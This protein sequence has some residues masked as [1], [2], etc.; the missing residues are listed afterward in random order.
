[1]FASFTPALAVA[2]TV[3]RLPVTIVAGVMGLIVGSFLN[4]V[5]YR[6]PRHLSVVRPPSFCPRCH[7][8]VGAIENVPVVSWL[9]LR[10]R[11]RHC[12]EPISPRYPL[13]EALTGAV[14]ALLGWVIGPHWAVLGCCVLAATVL[15]LA[16][17]ALDAMDPPLSVALMG[18]GIGTALLVVAG[19]ADHRWPRLVASLIGIGAGVVVMAVVAWV[20]RA[21]HREGE[22]S[23]VA[24]ALPV[25]ALVGWVGPLSGA[26]AA[27][28]A[29]IV[30]GAIS[31][32]RPEGRTHAHV[33]T[34]AVLALAIGGAIGVAVAAALGRVTGT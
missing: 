30:L 19:A 20:L 21:T 16:S 24:A 11:C 15:T 8:P 10:G 7:A 34:N 13:V 25:G 18:T 28:S 23:S 26:V 31:Q 29:V 9:A 3:G 22:V 12:G 1:M 27:A 5:V 33:T 4:V 32:W 14:F 17:V 2:V 6:V